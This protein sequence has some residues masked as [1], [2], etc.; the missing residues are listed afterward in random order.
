MTIKVPEEWYES[1]NPP[2]W[3]HIQWGEDVPKEL[4]VQVQAGGW[5][6]EVSILPEEEIQAIL[7]SI[8]EQSELELEQEKVKVEHELLMT[9]K[10][11]QQQKEFDMMM[12][13]KAK[14]KEMEKLKK[15]ML[16]IEALQSQ[17]NVWTVNWPTDGGGENP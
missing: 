8:P 10:K 2:S 17:S 15:Q 13:Q 16:D 11:I 4:L 6:L 1:Y 5:A 9:M 12:L 3:A 14:K 7:A